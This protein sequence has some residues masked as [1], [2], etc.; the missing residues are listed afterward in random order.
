[1][2]RRE[3][4]KV[5]GAALLGVS[6]FPLG[7]ARAAQKKQKILYFTRSVGFQHSPVARKTRDELSFSEKLMV[8][9]G[10]KRGVEVVCSKDG[11]I[12]DADLDQFDC[13]AFYT[14]GNLFDPN[15]VD[16]F[17]PMSPA[18]KQKL[19]AAVAGGKGFVG[20]HS[21]SDSFHSKGKQFETQT[22]VDPYI[23]MLGGEFIVHGRQQKAWMRVASPEFPGME[24]VKDFQLLEEW[25]ALKNFAKDLHVIL[26]Q[27]TAGM[28]DDCYQRP[29]Y[30]AT[31]ARKHGKGRVYFTSLGH[32]E[33]VWTNPTCQQIVL[34]GFDWALG[35][36]DADITP[37]ID[38]VTPQANQLRR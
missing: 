38:R 8:E 5:T 14:C 15:S 23:A 31:W 21:A 33:D 11:T 16:G 37:N 3:M 26:I 24:G 28:V 2:K 10:Q 6:A 1:M 29:P 20:F 35:N 27:D 17:P 9:E 22:E 34:G 4:L 12:F 7:W 18:G 36:V 30:P 32:R 25:Y 19:L 13:F